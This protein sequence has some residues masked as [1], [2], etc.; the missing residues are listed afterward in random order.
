MSRHAL[1][2][3][4][5]SSSSTNR[6]RSFSG[7]VVLVAMWCSLMSESTSML[8]QSALSEHMQYRCRAEFALCLVR[9]LFTEAASNY[10]L[11]ARAASQTAFGLPR[12]AGD[13]R[14]SVACLLACLRRENREPEDSQLQVSMSSHAASLAATLTDSRC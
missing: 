7:R 9:T 4:W 12:I 6:T 2:C 13:I 1:T 8:K 3:S 11:S 14:E 10:S 5:I